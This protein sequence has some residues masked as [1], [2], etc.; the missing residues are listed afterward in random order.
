MCTR[1][2]I[3]SHLLYEYTS[4]RRVWGKEEEQQQQQKRCTPAR[5]AAASAVVSTDSMEIIRL[6]HFTRIGGLISIHISQQARNWFF[7]FLFYTQRVIFFMMVM[8]TSSDGT[9]GHSVLIISMFTYITLYCII[10]YAYDIYVARI[11]PVC[12]SIKPL[13]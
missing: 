12:P 1:Y 11:R 10:M 7:L 9:V 6:Y 2:L 13:F 8:E 5:T 4:G 3:A